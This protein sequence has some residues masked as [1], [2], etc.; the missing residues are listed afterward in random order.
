MQRE[1][2]SKEQCAEALRQLSDADW[3]RLNEIARLRATGLKTVEGWDLLQEAIVRMLEGKRQWPLALPLP[4]FLRE[5]MRS[6]AS[7]LWRRQDAAVDV[8]ESEIDRNTETVDGVIAMAADMSTNPEAAVGAAQTLSQIE[9]M[10]KHDEHAQALIEGKIFGKS[11]E[12]I[13]QETGISAKQY[14]TTQR[15]IRRRLNRFSVRRDNCHERYTERTRT[16]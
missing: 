3:R 13:Q 14:A 11:P 16:P 7:D 10:F 12:E 6:I 1:T 9:E 4:V 2:A 8:V 15:R 5:T